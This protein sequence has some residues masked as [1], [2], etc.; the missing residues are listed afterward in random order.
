MSF[1]EEFENGNYTISVSTRHLYEKAQNL[2]KLLLKLD[3]TLNSVTN[4]VKGTSSYWESDGAESIRGEISDCISLA[5][6]LHKKLASDSSDLM[7]ITSIYESAEILAKY[8]AAELPNSL[9][10]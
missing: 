2:R 5:E 1:A 9:L 10:S 7:R 8:D 3:D 4:A 6:N